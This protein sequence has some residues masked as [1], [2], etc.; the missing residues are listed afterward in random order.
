MICVTEC[1]AAGNIFEE[2]VTATK[3]C[4]HTFV[5]DASVSGQKMFLDSGSSSSE[6][7]PGSKNAGEEGNEDSDSSKLPVNVDESL[8]QRCEFTTTALK[9]VVQNLQTMAA[10]GPDKLQ[11]MFTQSHIKLQV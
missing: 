5:G 4:A 8:Q 7:E 6:K 3:K 9:K 10:K 1:L 2:L 11:E